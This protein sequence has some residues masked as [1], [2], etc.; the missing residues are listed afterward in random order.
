MYSIAGRG[1]IN[2]GWRRRNARV[3]G[4]LEEEECRGWRRGGGEG[5]PDVEKGWWRKH[6]QAYTIHVC[7]WHIRCVCLCV[8]THTHT[9][10][11]TNQSGIAGQ[12]RRRG[13][14]PRRIFLGGFGEGAVVAMAGLSLSITLSLT[15]TH[16][17]SLSLTR[18]FFSLASLAASAS[19]Q[20]S[21]WHVSL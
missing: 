16:T 2:Q 8:M 17:H 21:L 11:H 1:G 6:A 15:H 20:S 12:E 14:P 7:V 5:M 4:G 18:S 19:A 9:H 10:T 13:I 3:G